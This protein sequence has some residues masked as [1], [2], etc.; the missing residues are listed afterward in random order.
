MYQ[1]VVMT[2]DGTTYRAMMT[3][4]RTIAVIEDG[5]DGLADLIEFSDDDRTSLVPEGL[6]AILVEWIYEMRRGLSITNVTLSLR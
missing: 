1:A 6:P 3:G 2:N 5:L 4:P